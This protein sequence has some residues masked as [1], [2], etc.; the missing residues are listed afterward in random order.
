LRLLFLWVFGQQLQ[1]HPS[2]LSF[3]GVVQRHFF[4]LLS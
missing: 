2:W 4:P 3:Y 1:R